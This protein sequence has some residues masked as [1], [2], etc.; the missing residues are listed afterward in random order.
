[1]NPV[2]SCC[3]SLLSSSVDRVTNE[4]YN[5]VSVILNVAPVGLLTAAIAGLASGSASLVALHN[6]LTSCL[7]KLFK[8][9]KVKKLFKCF[10]GTAISASFSVL[11]PSN[12]RV[13][14][15]L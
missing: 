5:V 14:L 8:C 2:F 6:F 3:E 1:M 7:K 13:M 9:E 12:P 4:T 11:L 15:V 10:N